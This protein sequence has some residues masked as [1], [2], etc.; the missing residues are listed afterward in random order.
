MAA[1]ASSRKR[2]RVDN[3]PCP[4]EDNGNRARSDDSLDADRGVMF[5]TLLVPW[6]PVGGEAEREVALT[7]RLRDGTLVA[8]ACDGLELRGGETAGGCPWTSLPG[9]DA[10]RALL[11]LH[12]VYLDRWQLELIASGAGTVTSR[13]ASSSSSAPDEGTRSVVL[14]LVRLKSRAVDGV[15]DAV[16]GS[17]DGV[18]GEMLR[19]LLGEIAKLREE[20]RHLAAG[21]FEMA[22]KVQ[23]RE[24]EL[25]AEAEQ[26]RASQAAELSSVLPLLLTKQKRLADLESELVEKGLT[27]EDVRKEAARQRRAAGESCGASSSSES[28][29]DCS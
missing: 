23:R 17:G 4:L 7:L 29:A 8:R 9:D 24:E 26:L 28:D 11:R 16:G 10:L 18:G 14:E 19:E 12:P 20:A 25:A 1:P 15:G 22:L 13:S 5:R 21:S 2:P 27:E 6:K 3:G